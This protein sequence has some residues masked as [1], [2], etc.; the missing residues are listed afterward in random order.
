MYPKYVNLVLHLRLIFVA[1]RYQ[2]STFGTPNGIRTRVCTLKGYRLGQLAYGDVLEVRDR[3][4][5]S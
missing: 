2:E 1:S 4:E 3:L 5:L